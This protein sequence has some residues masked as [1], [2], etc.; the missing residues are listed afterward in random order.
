LIKRLPVASGIGG[1]SA[2]AAAALRLLA[3]LWRVDPAD[4]ALALPLGADVPVCLD[5]RATRMGGIGEQLAA[6]P[7]LPDC[8]MVLINPGVAVSTPAVFRAR[9]P[10]FSPLAAL[11][12]AWADFADLVGGLA[13]LGNDLESAA[14]QLCPVIDDVLAALR[15]HPDC[16]LARMSGSG[17]TCYGLFT[18][19]AAAAAAAGALARPDWWCWGGA[20]AGF[21]EPGLAQNGAAT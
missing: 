17:A 3:R 20:M 18:T 2:D 11:P 8:G 21:A 6:A 15:H 9:H 4:L 14:R 10:R 1:G 16:A 12:A 13:M 19:P 5:S 7:G